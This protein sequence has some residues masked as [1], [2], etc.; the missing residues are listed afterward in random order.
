MDTICSIVAN[1][2]VFQRRTI[3][4]N[5]NR[6][7]SFTLATIPELRR[8]RISCALSVELGPI[9]ND[10]FVDDVD[11]PLIGRVFRLIAAC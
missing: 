8:G 2:N 1:G 9:D 7:L 11:L 4:K 3:L 6:L 5:E 10:C